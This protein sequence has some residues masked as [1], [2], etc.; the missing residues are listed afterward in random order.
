MFLVE[1]GR[2]LVILHG[3]FDFGGVDSFQAF[4]V[5]AWGEG[6]AVVFK[7]WSDISVVAGAQCGFH[8]S[9]WILSRDQ[10]VIGVER[11]MTRELVLY[12]EETKV[13]SDLE[14][15]RLLVQMVYVAH[16]VT[17]SGNPECRVL[18]QLQ[19]VDVAVCSAGVKTGL[20]TPGSIYL[21]PCT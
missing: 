11:K 1:Y 8:W 9:S 20:R 13:A 17:V 12:G 14:D 10:V 4:L 2:E 16:E 19:Y 18:N 21:W 15:A 5:V 7:K 6:G 3:V